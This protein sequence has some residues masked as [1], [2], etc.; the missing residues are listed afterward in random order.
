MNGLLDNGEAASTGHLLSPAEASSTENGFLLIEL[1]SKGGSI[2]TP[3]Q[4][5]LL[6]KLYVFFSLLLL[7]KLSPVPRGQYL[8]L[9]NI[10][11]KGYYKVSQLSRLNY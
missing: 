1:L 10:K 9:Y 3:K 11:T 2:G 6:P 5:R 8:I 4:L 7:S